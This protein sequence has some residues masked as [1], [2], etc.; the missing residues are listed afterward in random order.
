MYIHHIDY[1]ADSAKITNSE[2]LHSITKI[3]PVHDPFQRNIINYYIC[4]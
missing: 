1:K 4:T 2:T 3:P